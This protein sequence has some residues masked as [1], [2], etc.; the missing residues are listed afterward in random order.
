MW[1]FA[2]VR[3]E[4]G[5]NNFA[6]SGRQVGS[7][8]EAAHFTRRSHYKI[9]IGIARLRRN[10]TSTEKRPKAQRRCR[11]GAGNVLRRDTRSALTRRNNNFLDRPTFLASPDCLTRMEGTTG[12]DMNNLYTRMIGVQQ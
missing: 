9:R 7:A 6:G 3:A 4:N 2:G 10:A 11:H 8:C 1:D 12:K 5:E